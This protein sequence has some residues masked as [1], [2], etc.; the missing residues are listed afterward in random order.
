MAPMVVI[1]VVW[2]GWL[3]SWWTAAAWAN[4]VV[5][6]ASLL[7]QLPYRLLTFVGAILLFGLYSNGFEINH[8]LWNSQS[9]WIGWAMA[10]MVI[11]GFAFCW[12][13]RIRLGHLWSSAITR[14]TSHHIV[15]TGPYALVRHPIY[16]GISLASFATAIATGTYSSFI[17]A[18]LMAA[19]W[20]LKA[21][22]EERFLR[23]ELGP[24]AYNSYA[25]RVPMLVPFVHWP[26]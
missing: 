8:R 11:V 3:V 6:H 13:A 20:Y 14:K 10:I 15:D 4:P 5:K 18:I 19:G 9:G 17:G 22:I 12:W 7:Q 21:R 25:R 24:E 23:E 1:Y 16:T 26:I 2:A